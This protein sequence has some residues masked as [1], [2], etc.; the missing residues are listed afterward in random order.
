M[1]CVVSAIDS[2]ITELVK[3]TKAVKTEGDIWVCPEQS[4]IISSL[5]VGYLTAAIR[6]QYLLNLHQETDNVLFCGTAGI[7]NKESDL[8]IGDVVQS[9]S[10]CLCDGA[11]EIG[12]SV[13]T[14][15]LKRG[16]IES[17]MLMNRPKKKVKVLTALSFTKSNDLATKL[18]SNTN[19]DIENMELYGIAS[20][21]QGGR[22][23]WN[24]MLGL[25]NF[26]GENGHLEWITNHL[27]VEKSVC[28]RVF[29]WLSLRNQ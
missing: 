2:E 19:C 4:L 6:L 21:C 3:L 17:D 12:L 27:D 15:I 25:T 26:V 8:G 29:D 11:A 16:S 1:I 13:Y 10:T 7:Y 22:V 28:H 18:Y 20:V 14:S 9:H 5:G 24:S 23:R